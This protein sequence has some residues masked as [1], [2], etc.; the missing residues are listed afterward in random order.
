MSAVGI[1]VIKWYCETHTVKAGC[2]NFYIFLT[3]EYSKI[4]AKLPPTAKIAYGTCIP[5]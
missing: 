4:S 5:T 1:A 2:V 3:R